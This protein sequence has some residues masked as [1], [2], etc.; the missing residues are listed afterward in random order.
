MMGFICVVT[1]TML[2]NGMTQS[3]FA[4]T[5]L[6]SLPNNVMV[7]WQHEDNW[8]V[9]VETGGGRRKLDT[10]SRQ[11]YLLLTLGRGYIE[12]R[13][14]TTQQSGQT[15]DKEVEIKNI[16]DFLTGAQDSHL[17]TVMIP[18]AA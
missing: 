15:P 6:A 14:D 18:E 7:V 1:Q 9:T 3:I 12:A 11:S 2:H 13:T 16:T 8:I 4:V 5:I 17:Q 10:A